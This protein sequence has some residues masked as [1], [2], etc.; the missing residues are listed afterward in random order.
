MSSSVQRSRLCGDDWGV[1]Q[2]GAECRQK[3]T[4]DDCRESVFHSALPALSQWP[5][6]A[7]LS[8]AMRRIN[9][10]LFPYVSK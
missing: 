3:T 7:N 5:E 10:Y 1:G 2:S 6:R 8:S 9:F 4:G